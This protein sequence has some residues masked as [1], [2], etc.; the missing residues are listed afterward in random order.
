ME[1]TTEDDHSNKQNA[2]QHSNH[3]VVAT[4]Q[5]ANG[6]D[7]SGNELQPKLEETNHQT[8]STTTSKASETSLPIATTENESNSKDIDAE[9]NQEVTESSNVEGKAETEPTKNVAESVQKSPDSL[10]QQKSDLKNEE[11][12]SQDQRSPNSNL[13]SEPSQHRHDA[14]ADKPSSYQSSAPSTYLQIRALALQLPNNVAHASNHPNGHHIAPPTLI[15]EGRTNMSTA[16]RSFYPRVTRTL[17]ELQLWILALTLSFPAGIFS[18]FQAPSQALVTGGTMEDSVI[19]SY[20]STIT[21]QFARILRKPFVLSHP[22]TVALVDS[23][24]NYNPSMP[25][26]GPGS[27]VAARRKLDDGIAIARMGHDPLLGRKG[28]GGTGVSPTAT[29]DVD[30]VAAALGLPGVSSQASGDIYGPGTT[31]AASTSKNPLSI[32]SRASASPQRIQPYPTVPIPPGEEDED[33]EELT[34]ARN[35]ITRLELQFEKASKAAQMLV[36]RSGSMTATLYQLN[37]ALMDLARL[38]E[39]RNIAKKAKEGE[40]MSTLTKGIEAFAASRTGANAALMGTIVPSMSYQSLNAR[41]AIDALLRRAAAA[42]HRYQALVVLV[43]KRREAERLKRAR[44][45]IRQE[46]VDWVLQELRD[47]QRTTQVLTHHLTT[48]TSTLKEELKEHSRNTHTDI[49]DALINHAKN[50]I[51]A[52]K[53]MLNN[54]VRARDGLVALREGKQVDQTVVPPLVPPTQTDSLPSADAAATEDREADRVESASV[55]PSQDTS[56]SNG[57]V[58]DPVL[59]SRPHD[60]VPADTAASASIASPLPEQVKTPS[61]ALSSA[62]INKDLPDAPT[63]AIESERANVEG[64][65]PINAQNLRGNAG[66]KSAGPERAFVPPPLAEPNSPWNDTQPE[67]EVYSAPSFGSVAQSAFLPPTPTRQSSINDP[68]NST[69]SSGMPHTAPSMSQSAFLPS[70]RDMN[71]YANP[72]ARMEGGSSVSNV[73]NSG[74]GPS[75]GNQPGRFAQQQQSGNQTQPSPASNPN[76]TTGKPGDVWANRSRLSASDAARSLAG[77]F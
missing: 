27:S 35:E 65:P 64:P 59:A 47:A 38:D 1:A 34:A 15:V 8:K 22:A 6:N 17:P 32:F 2:I 5:E 11:S 41:A 61:S 77:R 53:Y 70:G 3:E 52:H 16:R 12:I 25:H 20:L 55:K 58:I 74:F 7:A 68:F 60:L 19:R 30:G 63:E 40:D 45:E 71:R 69:S 54:L 39:G 75:F 33:E 72:F 66:S 14:G 42:S 49:Q 50:S 57:N 48:F 36:E 4:N 44:G 46:D 21:H 26:V 24:F 67:S 62:S 23:D 43:Q 56:I 73:A 9:Y 29:W 10:E 37:S 28:K 18:P 51:R 13:K 76:G 31:P